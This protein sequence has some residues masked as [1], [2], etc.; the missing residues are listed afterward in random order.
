M[1]YHSWVMTPE[2]KVILEHLILQLEH[3]PE[4]KL[5]LIRSIVER[6]GWSNSHELLR[7]DIFNE[8]FAVGF[9]GVLQIH[10]ALSEA[11]FSKDKFEWGIVQ[12]LKGCGRIAK[13]GPRGFSGYDIEVDQERWS[14]KTQA[15]KGIRLDRLHIS[16]F[17][18]LGKGKWDDE[19]DLGLLRD[20]MIRHLDGYDRIFALRYFDQSTMMGRVHFYELI[21]I[22]KSLLAQAA[23][24]TISM[25]HTSS[26]K[27]KPGYCRVEGKFELYF[28]GG[29]ERKLQIKNLMKAHCLVHATWTITD[30]ATSTAS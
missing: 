13:T 22:P 10:H 19:S 29:S 1:C 12:V 25:V 17:K 24:G 15:D 5:R 14:L 11:P 6:L 16:K 18:E 2:S 9:E 20:Q 26:Q 28:D 4:A 30:L 27:P 3:L 21:E 8:C 7:N 23:N